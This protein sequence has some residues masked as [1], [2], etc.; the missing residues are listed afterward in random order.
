MTLSKMGI[1]TGV[2]PETKKDLKRKEA[3]LNKSAFRMYLL[4]VS[5]YIKSYVHRTGAISS[6][7]DVVQVQNLIGSGAEV[8]DPDSVTLSSSDGGDGGKEDDDDVPGTE[9]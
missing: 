9:I 1:K 5:R 7:D 6:P 3:T 4:G 8:V 2:E